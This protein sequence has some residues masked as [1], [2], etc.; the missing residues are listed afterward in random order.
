MRVAKAPLA[1][2]PWGGLLLFLACAPAGPGEALPS[3]TPYKPADCP[4]LESRL[5]QLVT[6]PNPT[7]FARTSDLAYADGSV[8]VVIEL[9]SKDES[10]PPG[11][12]IKVETRSNELVQASV[13][14][15]EL[16][17]LSNEPQVK[18]IREPFKAVPLK[19]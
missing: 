4:K 5:Y 16:C 2:I 13:P 3:A 9:R 17:K 14:L 1:I 15:N 8:R 18:F 10:L 11:Y 6:A 12:S 19:R 7:E